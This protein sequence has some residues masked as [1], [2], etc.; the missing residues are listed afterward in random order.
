MNLRFSGGEF[1]ND[2]YHLG[3]MMGTSSILQ[4][5]IVIVDENE[6]IIC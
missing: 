4:G 2:G 3:N 5:E 6:L 1:G